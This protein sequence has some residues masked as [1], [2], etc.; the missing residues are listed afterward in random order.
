[1]KSSKIVL[2]TFVLGILFSC[3]TNEPLNYITLHCVESSESGSR[4]YLVNIYKAAKDTNTVLISNFHNISYEGDYDVM[5]KNENG[6]LTFLTEQIGNSQF[7]I[8]SPKATVNANFTQMTFD[9]NIYNMNDKS[10]IGFHA[11]YSR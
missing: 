8:K 2:L 6:N 3:N 10:E 4:T 1:M 5:V 11:V 7:V 9:Y